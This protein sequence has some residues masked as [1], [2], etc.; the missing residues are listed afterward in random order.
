QQRNSKRRERSCFFSKRERSQNILHHSQQGANRG[1]SLH[2][3]CARVHFI[4][5]GEISA[6]AGKA[7]GGA[8][9]RCDAWEEGKEEEEGEEEWLSTSGA[10]DLG[11]PA[12]RW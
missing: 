2:M 3:R 8:A 5:A 9:C 1:S 10:G 11:L 12:D 4:W 6:A 7:H